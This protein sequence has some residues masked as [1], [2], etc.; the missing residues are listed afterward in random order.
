M[1]WRI[2]QSC[3]TFVLPST[4]FLDS[5]SFTDFSC[6]LPSFPSPYPSLSFL[7][8]FLLICSAFFSFRLAFFFHHL[9]FIHL[10]HS[11]IHSYIIYFSFT[12]SFLIL[13]IFLSFFSSF[14]FYRYFFLSILPFFCTAC[15][16][17]FFPLFII[18]LLL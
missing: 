14:F 6:V 17:S 13:S 10:F 7:S 18:R 4:S 3:F 2:W 11:L 15:L 1:L 8:Y 12:Q 9:L 16:S 5:Y